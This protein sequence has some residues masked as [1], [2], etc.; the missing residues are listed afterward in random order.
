VDAGAIARTLQGQPARIR[1]AV[2]EAR[3]AALMGVS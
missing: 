1:Q 2:H 3:L